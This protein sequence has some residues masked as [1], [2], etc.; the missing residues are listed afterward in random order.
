[1]F[2]VGLIIT[3]VGMLGVFT[4]LILLVISMGFMSKIIQKFL[5]EKE[6][7]V[8]VRKSSSTDLEIAIAI[9]AIKNLS[10]GESN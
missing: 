9:A 8:P 10:S 5:P 6:V 2:D 1:M 3:L 4:F 7:A